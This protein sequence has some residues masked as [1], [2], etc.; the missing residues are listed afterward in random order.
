MS[1]DREALRELFV[2]WRSEFEAD[3][4]DNAPSGDASDLVLSVDDR[5]TLD[6]L[7]A[8]WEPVLF[9]DYRL[10]LEAARRWTQRQLQRR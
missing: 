3:E 10:L 9:L 8:E 5:A 7:E 1:A 4:P 6:I 2:Q